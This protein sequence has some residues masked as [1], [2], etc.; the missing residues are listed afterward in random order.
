MQS[1]YGFSTEGTL[2]FDRDVI[3]STGTRPSQKSL[4]RKK[5]LSKTN[6]EYNQGW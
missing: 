3:D 5:L 2:S 6:N 1:A 4:I